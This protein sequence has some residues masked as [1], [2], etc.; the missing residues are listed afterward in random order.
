[1]AG[2]SI[3]YVPLSEEAACAALRAAG[4]A[5]DLIER[6][7]GFYRIVRQ[8]LCAPV[9]PDAESILGRPTI[10]FEQYARDHAAAWR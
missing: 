3:A 6:W 4:V 1:V 9:V 8:G 7:R 2:R 10:A 5:D